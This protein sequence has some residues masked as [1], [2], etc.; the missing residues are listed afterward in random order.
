MS[1]I[2]V[3][4]V[5]I[6]P[7]MKGAAKQIQADLK[8]IDTSS[9]GADMGKNLSKSMAASMNMQ[10]VGAKIQSIGSDISSIGSALTKSITVPIAGAAIAAGG[11]VATLGWKRLVSIDSAQAQLRG[12]GYTT[13]DVDRITQNLVGALE[14]GMLTMGQAT[15]AAAAGMAA[16]VEEGAE[17]TRYIQL[18]DAAT[19][20][21]KGTFDEMNQIFARVQ[22][23]GKLLTNE[24]GMMEQ[25]MPG[26]TGKMAEAAGVTQESFREMVSAGEVSA[27]DFLGLFE[28]FGSEMATEYA[29]SWEGMLQN[30]WAYIGI[31]GE[32]LLGGVFEQSKDSIA[33]FIEY[34]SS[35]EV[36]AWAADAGAAIGDAFTQIVAWVKDAINWW[37]SLDGETQK[38][39]LTITGIAVAAGPVLKIL[40][41]LV[42]LVG[43]MVSAAGVLWGWLGKLAGGFSLAGGATGGFLSV[44]RLIT[45]PVG[46]A[47][48]ALSL[49]WTQSESFRNGIKDLGIAVWEALQ[50]IGQ[51]FQRL[52]NEGIKPVY[53]ALKPATES[54]F[55]FFQDWVLPVIEA[56]FSFIFEIIKG[57]INNIVNMFSGMVDVITGVVSLVAAVFQGD[58]SA[59]WES[60]KQIVSG[61]VKFVWNLIQAVL[62]ISILGIIR[63]FAKT[64]ITNIWRPLF[65]S[66][67]SIVTNVLNAVRTFITN[68]INGIR[69]FWQGS[70]TAVRNTTTSIFNGIRSTITTIMNAIRSVITTIMNAIRASITAVWNAIRAVISAVVNGIRAVVT[71]GFGAMR[72]ISIAAA[73][74]I[75][76]GVST[77][78][79]A[80][81]TLVVNAVSRMREGV[82]NGFTAMLDFVRNIPS[83]IMGIFSNIGSLLLNSGKALIGGFTEGIRNAFSGAVDAVKA[84]VQ[85]VRNFLPFSPAK[86]GPFSGKGY[87]LYS[88][89]ALIEDFGK[90]IAGASPDA[91]REMSKA[92]EAIAAETDISAAMPDFL[93]A[94]WS[95]ASVPSVAPMSG[96]AGSRV[97]S[98]QTFEASLVGAAVEIGPDGLAR[99]IDGR[100]VVA[101][102][103]DKVTR[104][105]RQSAQSQARRDAKAGAR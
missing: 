72:T 70:F 65:N 96:G 58:W 43:K 34:L 74:G 93:P 24:L 97:S 47:V 100:V 61:A 73:N 18:L 86:E 98:K 41:P 75:R 79:N 55:G 105:S 31:L 5:S 21:S 15:S 60:L 44:L 37:Q 23:S 59:A 22:G 76:S 27:S 38:L 12:L 20:G 36:Q 29:K 102:K 81:R 4:Y 95:A 11:L 51:E 46:I 39:I 77:A 94:S 6:V 48:G 67:R 26:F 32:A 66:V 17:L 33:E 63:N 53:D 92:A 2:G 90:G 1:E 7:S 64:L 83:R 69:S 42:T 9:A 50:S 54:A 25:R 28:S 14:G 13:E 80:A 99:F 56:V 10:A 62:S 78:F 82:R 85:K 68:I 91:I 104:I 40:G 45:G 35:E 71:G 19:A 57:V 52:W 103:D 8:G 84:G 30:T 3:Y 89:Q 101:M 49:L 88:G 87:T 16:G